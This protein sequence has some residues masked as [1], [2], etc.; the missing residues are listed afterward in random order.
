[1]FY[2]VKICIIQICSPVLEEPALAGHTSLANHENGEGQTEILAK[3]R[4][5]FGIS[6]EDII[7]I[8]ADHASVNSL[9]IDILNVTFEWK[10]ELVRCMP[11]C[12]S[13]V[14]A[15]FVEAWN[16]VYRFKEFFKCQLSS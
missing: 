7:F 14:L 6:K 9:A 2:G 5:E 11:H 12:A 3:I 4:E 8:G 1:L 15:A 13:L 10:V 16:V